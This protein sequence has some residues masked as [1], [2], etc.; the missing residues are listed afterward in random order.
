MKTF[1]YDDVPVIETTSGKLKGYFYD[2]TYI[3]K[4]VPYAHA[5]RV[6]VT[7][8]YKIMSLLYNIC[9]FATVINCSVNI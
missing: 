9:T 7:L 4:G 5:N 3:F 6:V 1:R 8:N 2:G